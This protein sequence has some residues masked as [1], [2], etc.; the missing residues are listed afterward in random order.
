M[1]TLI[2]ANLAYLAQAAEL[3][4]RIDDETFASPVASFY[5]SSVG[6]HLRHCLEHYQSFLAGL[7]TG[8]IDYDDR[9]RDTAI[10]TKTA[11]AAAAIGD[12]TE[13]LRSLPAEPA[14]ALEVKMD[15]GVDQI[16]WQPSSS[17]RELQF[18]VSHTV[19][20]FAM[21]GG[22]C[23]ALGVAVDHGFGVAPST[24]R[25]RATLQDA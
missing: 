13:R 10:E 11:S 14:Q 20:H 17:G 5:D 16:E 3:L 4:D 23:Q 19:H 21:I 6:G 2:S 18:L 9:K 12:I 22:I 1:E 24:L 7:E 25:H 8:R 15:C